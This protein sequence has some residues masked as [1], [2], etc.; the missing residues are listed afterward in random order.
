[1]SESIPRD[2]SSDTPDRI[3]AK[4]PEKPSKRIPGGDG[5][6]GDDLG[7]KMSF[8]QHLDE[9]RRRI[10][11]CSLAVAVTFAAAFYFREWIYDF[12]AAP[13]T[14]V[15]TERGGSG[16]LVFTKVTDAFTIWLKV[17]F[18][19]A[20]FAASPFLVLQIWLF[21]APGLYRKEKRFAIPFLFSSTVLFLAGGAFCY[22][23][24]MPAGLQFLIV[25]MG[26]KFQPV[27][28]ANDF[29]TFEVIL[30]LG[31]GAVFQMPVLVAFLSLF[32]LTSPRFLIKN[33]RYAVL[34][35]TIVAAVVSP[36]PDAL[37]LF[38][39]AGPMIVLYIL[40]IG[41]SW[42]FHRRRKKREAM[43]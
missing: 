27:L 36:T 42:I 23:V 43:A 21:I 10:V 5:P 28:T 33:F 12:L 31:M 8:L 16:E 20:V 3:L 39:W 4:S 32:G 29:F 7:G 11:Y 38:F 24:I 18:A 6:S 25:E 30:L 14:K 40:S 2:E 41:I 15:L 37:N 19:A 35:I 9:L 1:M 17:S 13:I 26:A 22:L 34:I